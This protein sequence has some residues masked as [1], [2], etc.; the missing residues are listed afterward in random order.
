MKKSICIETVFTE[1]PFEERFSL[2]SEAGFD[3]IEFWSWEDKNLKKIK[4]LCKENDLEISSFSGDKDY[5]LV[6]P[7]ENED[8][9]NYIKLS[10][11][12]AK[13]LNCDNLV[14]HSNALGE[15]G[16]VLDSYDEI[17][18]HKKFI[19]MYK[20]LSELAPLAEEAEV[21]LVLE[22]LNTYKD[23][24]GNCLAHTKDSAELARMV[25]SSYIKVLFDAYH[26]QIMEGNIIEN[27]R[28]YI[29]VID[30]IHVADSPD[31]SEPGTGEINYKN[32]FKELE[33]LDYS[34]FLGFELFP[35]KES[36]QVAVEL[37]NL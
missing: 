19:N 30:Y 35:K 18:E 25:D 10:I 7:Q 17:S 3:Y 37:I 31:R 5:S 29:D 4:R 36:K 27:L 23:H 16:V 13:F 6:N 28:E 32:I 24:D 2:A 15:G 1:Y 22:A 21:K 9:I 11:E 26:M 12:K 8:Y 20:V 33:T 34:H 14:I